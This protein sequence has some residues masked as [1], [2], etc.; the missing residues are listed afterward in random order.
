MKKILC[1]LLCMMLVMISAESL[2]AVDYTLQE[3]M[4]KQL[5]SG[6][7][8]KGTLQL[9]G[10]GNDPFILSLQPFQDVE[11]QFR[12]MRTGEQGHYYFYQAGDDESQKGLT[13]IFDDG[14]SLFFRSDFLPGEVIRFPALAALADAMLPSRGGNPSIA[15]A[16]VR[17]IQTGKAQQEAL[18]N[19]VLEILEKQLEVWLAR[20]AEASEVKTTE[21]GTSA[22]ELSYSI[23]MDDFRQE[24]VSL[25]NIL[26][27]SAEGK[28]LMDQ[29]FS[30]EQKGLFENQNLG[31][32]FLDALSALNN[33]YDINYTSTISTLG[34]QLSSSL[35]LP[36][37]ESSMGF[38]SLL[39]ED[40]NG[41]ISYT[42]R[43]D[44]QVIT[45]LM[46]RDYDWSQIDSASAWVIMRPN[47]NGEETEKGLYH[48]I[49]LE[50]QHSSEKTT[51]EESRDHER[52]VWK[53]TA[54]RDVSRLPEG[55]DEKNYPEELPLSA[56][57]NLHY[58]SRYSQSSPTT[59]EYS[60]S[61]IREDFLIS[62]NG[63][64]KT[65]SPWVFSPFSTEGAREFTTFSANELTVKIAEF[66]AG[67]SEQLT[68]AKTETAEE[69][70]EGTNQD[71]NPEENQNDAE[72]GET[73]STAAE[74]ETSEDASS[75]EKPESPETTSAD[76]EGSPSETAD[77]ADGNS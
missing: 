36:L 75:A 9:H 39:I 72:T 1:A 19:P 60:L 42:L 70:T 56:E 18:L 41:L 28:A 2:A 12:G 40:K 51:D 64:M 38:K 53:L 73:E 48:A 7:G 45:L 57:L 31:Y 15:S 13:E 10:E 59:L 76:P 29:I 17:W 46:G 22:V 74:M 11:L 62:G 33:E 52:T 61:I 47:P 32:Y 50:L 27:N 34:V 58:F 26:Q 14:S 55:E 71:Q 35:E 37:D 24:I 68:P 8:L 65:S 30:E 21:S 44:E 66:L 5:D 3:K 6:S 23:P 20:Y 25:M 63:Q 69:N 77:A 49:R 54:E 4:Q 16:A 43:N 67:A